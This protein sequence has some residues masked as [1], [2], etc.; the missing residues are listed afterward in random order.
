MNTESRVVLHFAGVFMSRVFSLADEKTAICRGYTLYA[1]I[2]W[3]I[4]IH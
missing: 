3:I 1:V 2:I 4:I